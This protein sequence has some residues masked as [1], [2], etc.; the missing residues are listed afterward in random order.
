MGVCSDVLEV[1]STITSECRYSG[2]QFYPAGCNYSVPAIDEDQTSTGTTM[3]NG[4]GK[5]ILWIGASNTPNYRYPDLITLVQ[6]YVIY[7]P[8]LAKWETFD[9]TDDHKDDLTAFQI[10]LSLCLYRYNTTMVNGIT[11]TTQIDKITDIEWQTDSAV[12]DDGTTSFNTLKTTHDSETFWM[13]DLNKKAF[14]NYLTLQTFTGYAS[15]SPAGSHKGFNLTSSDIVREIT[16]S[17]Y[18]D[19]PQLIA[20]MDNLAVSMTNGYVVLALSPNTSAH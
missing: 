2:R 9:L 13:S 19:P 12:E 8:D 18:N 4:Q 17:V 1:S 7:V 3:V 5:Q 10:N 16:S 14:F 20:L 11:T 6:F 15:M